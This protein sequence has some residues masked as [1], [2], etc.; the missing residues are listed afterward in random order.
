V[1]GGMLGTIGLAL[2]TIPNAPVVTTIGA[3]AITTQTLSVL[4]TGVAGV[5]F[6][7]GKLVANVRDTE[8]DKQ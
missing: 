7:Y 5:W 4:I 6:G 2:A 3:V 1:W 8:K